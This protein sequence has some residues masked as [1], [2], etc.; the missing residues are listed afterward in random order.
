MKRLPLLLLGLGALLALGI[1]SS[2]VTQGFQQ[3]ARAEQE[4]AELEAEKARLER[5][6]AEIEATLEALRRSPEA[7][8]S[9]ARLELGWIR[10]GETV[11]ILA[12]PTL[13]P[14][15]VSAAEPTPTPIYSLPR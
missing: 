6:I 14:L 13:A 7:V 10:P 5:S 8:E 1:L 15:P 3:V 4:R 11:L 9:M 2:V 12:T